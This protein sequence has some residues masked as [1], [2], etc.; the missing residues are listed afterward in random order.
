VGD[1][2]AVGEPEV[3]MG[4]VKVVEWGDD[5]GGVDAAVELE[6]QMETVTVV[7]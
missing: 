5:V 6:G 1:V 7:V 2:D 4:M 3:Q